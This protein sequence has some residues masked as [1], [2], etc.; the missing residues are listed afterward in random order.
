[1]QRHA[2]KRGT[3]KKTTR[4]QSRKTTTLRAKYITNYQTPEAV[5]KTILDKII[6]LSI[7][8]STI[9]KINNQLKSY[10]FEYIQNQIEPLFEEKYINYSRP[11]NNTDTL[12]WKTK[13][14]VENQWVEVKEPETLPSDRFEGAFTRIKELESKNKKITIDQIKEGLENDI[15]LNNT[16]EKEASEEEN[17]K[18]E[19]NKQIK[20]KLIL[21]EKTEKKNNNKEEEE[22]TLNKN[23]IQIPQTNI[24]KPNKKIQMVNFPSLDIPDIEK[25]FMHEVYDPPN[26]DKLR[27]EREEEIKKKEREKKI[28]IDALK[29]AKKKDDSEKINK[30]IKPL[31]SNKYTFDSNGQIMSFKQYKLDNL[32]K[33][34]TF[35]KNSIK[36][37]DRIKPLK[38]KKISIKKDQIIKITEEVIKNPNN[39]DEENKEKSQTEKIKDKKDRVIPSGSNFQIILPNIGVVIKENQKIKEGGREFNKYFNKYSIHDYDKILNEYVP[40]QNKTQMRSK[41][42]AL[43]LTTSN[44]LKKKMSESV[45]NTRTIASQ[46]NF[47]NINKTFIYNNDNLNTNNP[48]LSTND[49]IQITIN[50]PDNNNK[51]VNTSPYLKTSINSFNTNTNNYNPLMTSLNLKSAFMNYSQGKKGINFNSSI[52]MKKPGSTSLKL[53]IENMQDLKNDRAYYESQNIKQ[54]NIFGKNFMKNYKIALIKQPGNNSLS[55]F[56]KTILTDTNWGNQ[57]GQKGQQKENI[58]FARH[59][60][61]QQALREL[62]SNILSGIK[63]KLPRDRK[64]EINK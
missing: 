5:V 32:T 10:C 61:K 39:E 20:K 45:D 62:G 33:D 54:K 27:K 15:L 6:N 7:R 9:N 56:N 18:T 51:I 55:P 60:T 24:K 50:D 29:M 23:K 38:K 34:F 40:L 31:D 26:I 3:R 28:Q 1:M 46:N 21:T 59:H 11:N 63:I 41:M 25:E 52:T 44:N 17:E 22:K 58:V 8:Q 42:E 47:N 35:I 19:N 49:N 36:E 57:T 16:T 2:T 53:E 30:K 48:L 4:V 13:I 64:V 37:H 14:P 12:F 43:N